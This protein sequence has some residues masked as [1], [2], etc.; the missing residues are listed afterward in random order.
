MEDEKQII[1]RQKREIASL[2]KAI[3]LLM[4]KQSE[5]KGLL[6]PNTTFNLDIAG[7]YGKKEI[8]V[9]IKR[10]QLEA[11]ALGES[12]VNEV[13]GQTLHE[14]ISESLKAKGGIG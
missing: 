12:K 6:S 9:L 14:V 10:L 3:T 13:T 4:T 2:A 11:K 5:F 7:P 1:Q 8:G